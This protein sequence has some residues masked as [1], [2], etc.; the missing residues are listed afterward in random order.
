MRSLSAGSC[1]HWSIHS[2]LYSFYI[3]FLNAYCEPSAEPGGKV[4]HRGSL[5]LEVFPNQRRD[6]QAEG[7]ILT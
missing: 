1:S 2:F 6:S 7:S 3:H 4:K 5:A